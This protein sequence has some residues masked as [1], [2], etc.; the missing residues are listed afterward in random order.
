MGRGFCVKEG[1]YKMEMDA[2]QPLK[3]YALVLLEKIRENEPISKREL[4]NIT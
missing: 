4:Q 3:S 2:T 1:N